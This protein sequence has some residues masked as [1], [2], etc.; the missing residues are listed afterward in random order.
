MSNVGTLLDPAEQLWLKSGL[1]AEFL[2]HLKL[3]DDPDGV[4]NSSFK[5]GSAAQVCLLSVSHFK[6]L[7]RNVP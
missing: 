5:L 7:T 1:P 2:S 4:V 3:S 6:L